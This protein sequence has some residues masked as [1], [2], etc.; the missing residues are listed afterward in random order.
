MKRSEI[1]RILQEYFALTRSERRGL[2]V[3]SLIL[4]LSAGFHFVAD[5]INFQK[6]TDFTSVKELLKEMEQSAPPS[7]LAK[8]G[9][10]FDFDPNTIDPGQL[11]S[12]DLPGN[13]IRNLVRY[14]TSGGIFKTR[15]DL[16]KLYGMTD[17]VYNR[18]APYIRIQTK[19]VKP[20]ET[21]VPQQNERF[22]FDP[23]T[24]GAEELRKLGLNDFQ[25]GN[26]ISFREKGG[27]FKVPEDMKKIY[28]MDDVLFQQLDPY[29]QIDFF[30]KE[31]ETAATRPVVEINS[32][33][34]LGL[35]GIPGIGPVFASRIL[36]YREELGGFYSLDQISEVYGMTGDRMTQII[37][38]LLLDTVRI[39]RIRLNFADVDVLRSH[40]YI[41]AGQARLI[42]NA[43]SGRGPYRELRELTDHQLLGE[44]DL[45]KLR[46][47]LSL[48]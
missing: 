3:L 32:A 33:D 31:E 30:G 28:G 10:L 41:S 23:N 12:L 7:A 45:K 20:E 29:I 6:E 46:P 1:R 39:R 25:A 18:I 43:R 4:I 36:K 8:S 13:I 15:E 34:S 9:V 48:P 47:Y 17:S 21:I 26:L 37:P 42:V 5:H 22:F 44:E 16:K 24:A 40:P 38:Y 35:L 19:M 27:R 11:D 2:S 14:R